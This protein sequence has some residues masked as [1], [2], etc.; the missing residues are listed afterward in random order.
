MVQKHR[1]E[2][3]RINDNHEK[4]KRQKIDKEILLVQKH[5]QEIEQINDNHEKEKIQ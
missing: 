5:Q 3:E 4:E 2:I 1:K